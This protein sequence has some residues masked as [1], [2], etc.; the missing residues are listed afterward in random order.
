[1]PS[2]ALAPGPLA[3]GHP[4]STA[5]MPCRLTAPGS[6]RAHCNRLPSPLEHGEEKYPPPP[7]SRLA[8]A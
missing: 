3:A 6:R 7:A 2:A 1:M 5:T 8:L 4:L